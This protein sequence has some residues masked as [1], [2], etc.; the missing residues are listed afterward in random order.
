MAR[1][2]RKQRSVVPAPR[3]RAAVAPAGWSERR[4]AVEEK[5]PPPITKR[6]NRTRELLKEAAARVL[7]R[8]GYRAMRLADIAAEADVNVSLVYHYFSGKADITHEILT[9]LIEKQIAQEASTRPHG[10]DVFDRIVT[11]N[12]V[13]VE[14]YA[15]TPGL[16]RCLLQLDEEAPEFSCAT[17]RAAAR[18]PPCR[19]A[20]C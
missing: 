2:P 18:S 17:S 12:L 6:G 16:M 5:P 7:E 19:R 9:E 20:S 13:T 4:N 3:R 1:G 8:V 11:A 15:Q 10:D 14:A